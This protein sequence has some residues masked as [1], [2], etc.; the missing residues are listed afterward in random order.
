MLTPRNEA[1]DP[2]SM[3]T[4]CALADAASDA[5]TTIANSEYRTRAQQ[6]VTFMSLSQLLGRY[7]DHETNERMCRTKGAACQPLDLEQNPQRW[8]N[9]LEL[10]TSIHVFSMRDAAKIFGRIFSTYSIDAILSK[11]RRQA[12]F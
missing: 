4:V 11:E 12:N 3:S 2:K 10:V 7:V 5:P 8:T 6:L 1:A 9:Y